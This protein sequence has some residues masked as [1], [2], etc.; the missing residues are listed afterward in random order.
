[1]TKKLAQFEK[2]PPVH[3]K[4]HLSFWLRAFGSLGTIGLLGFLLYR[5]GWH[6]IVQAAKLIPFKNL[7]LA[8]FLMGISRLA[9]AT[10]WHILLKAVKLPV[11][12]GQSI[13]I[14]FA[15]LFASNFLPTTIGG[16]LV[17]V[18]FIFRLGFDRTISA[19]SVFIDRLIG[20]AG[21]ALFLPF[22]I[23]TLGLGMINPLSGTKSHVMFGA[24][25]I[26][27]LWT[28]GKTV[29]QRVA[30]AGSLWTKEPGAAAL[31]LVF[32]LIHQACLYGTLGLVFGGLNENLTYW[33]I[34][35][36]WSFI[37]FVTLLPVS[38]NGLGVQEV[39]MTF[40]FH[41]FGGVPLETA[42]TGALLFRT[43]FMLASTPGALYL[44]SI[45]SLAKGHH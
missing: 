20:M 25:S 13:P 1:M 3:Q 6:E 24:A 19:T 2:K 32:S 27:Q 10:R 29:L 22:G 31:A 35:G 36:L 30:E 21:M 39:S 4:E 8:M 12:L 18:A 44:P 14:T 7:V 9:T 15:G 37:Y 41:N 40:I 5:Q 33:Q 23:Q 17:R 34:G 26:T 11:N 28:R 45:L 42:L 16:D 43:L 38:I